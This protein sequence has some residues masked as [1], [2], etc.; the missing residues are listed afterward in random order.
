MPLLTQ[1]E[2]HGVVVALISGG[3]D[4]LAQRSLLL[5]SIPLAYSSMLQT[6]GAPNLQ[7]L[8]D[9][10]AMN[11]RERLAD[12]TVPLEIY[13]RNASFLLSQTL[14]QAVILKALDTVVRRTSGAPKIDLPKVLSQTP[15]KI[16]HSDD[17]VPF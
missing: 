7:A 12:G 5:Q 1:A 17:L 14:Q 16:V 10:G 4:P 13:L 2:L 3:I 6:M 11:V 15:E 8:G 9:L